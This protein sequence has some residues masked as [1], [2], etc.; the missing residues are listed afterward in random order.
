MVAVQ[1]AQEYECVSPAGG[2]RRLG[3]DRVDSVDEVSHFP[4]NDSSACAG[5]SCWTISAIAAVPPPV[6]MRSADVRSENWRIPTVAVGLYA[7]MLALLIPF[8]RDRCAAASS[9]F[10][11]RPWTALLV[12]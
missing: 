12:L 2:Y 5:Q 8:M 4:A 10:Y 1:S 3:R 7:L 9:T 6:N 11:R